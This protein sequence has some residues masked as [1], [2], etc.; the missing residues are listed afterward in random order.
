M[1][2]DPNIST[3][4]LLREQRN[5]EVLRAVDPVTY[6]HLYGGG[7]APRPIP[8]TWWSRTVPVPLGELLFV[9]LMFI[10][11]GGLLGFALH[12]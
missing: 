7:P 10:A 6:L 4:A 9:S 3:A 8:P 12:G 1:T 11:G 2:P 5:R